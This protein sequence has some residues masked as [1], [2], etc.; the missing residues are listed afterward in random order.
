MN[1][2]TYLA[3]YKAWNNKFADITDRVIGVWTNGPYSHVEYIVFDENKG[4]YIMCSALGT[5]NCV[6]CK[7]H[8]FNTLIYD[9]IEVEIENPNRVVEFFELIEGSK[10]DFK[11]IIL[12][13]IFPLG[14][15]NPNEWFCSESCTKASQLSG[16]KNKDL[17]KVKPESI[18]PND[19]A[20][21][22]GLIETDKKVPFYKNLHLLFKQNLPDIYKPFNIKKVNKVPEDQLPYNY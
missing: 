1:H 2:K 15:D 12:S 5:C 10:Y 3:F 21:K 11:G 13:Q 19:L 20:Y 8:E 6:R 18:S 4:H 7:K 22:L 14:M 17:W 9:Y 16:I